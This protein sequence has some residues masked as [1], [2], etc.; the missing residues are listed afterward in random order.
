MS[1][2]TIYIQK[3]SKKEVFQF[4]IKY[5]IIKK[6]Y[7]IKLFNFMY[8]IPRFILYFVQIIRNKR[9]VLD[10]GFILNTDFEQLCELSASAKIQGAMKFIFSDPPDMK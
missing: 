4:E 9:L 7:S 5:I 8:F 6:V 2:L 1:I 3:T 10:S